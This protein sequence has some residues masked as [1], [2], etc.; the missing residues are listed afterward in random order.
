MTRDEFLAYCRQQITTEYGC[1]PI[2]FDDALE[3]IADKYA[4]EIEWFD[5]HVCEGDR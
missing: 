3:R 1:V 2:D 4:E 5:R